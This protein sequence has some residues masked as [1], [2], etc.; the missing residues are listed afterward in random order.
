M[1]AI[2]AYRDQGTLTE[3]VHPILVPERAEQLRIQATLEDGNVELVVRIRVDTKVFD[4]VQGDRLVLGSRGI[5]RCITL[6][7]V[8]K[9]SS[10]GSADRYNDKG[11]LPRD[12]IGKH[13][14]RLYQQR[15]SC[16]G[17][18]KRDGSTCCCDTGSLHVRRRPSTG[19]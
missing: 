19:H 11:G 17:R 7:A 4:F 18:S 16:W 9:I 2:A 14:S 3:S 8:R 1:A 12:N 10:R 6:T 13:Q 5:R 15:W